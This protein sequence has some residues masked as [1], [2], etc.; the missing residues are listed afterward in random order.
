[1]ERARSRKSGRTEKNEWVVVATLGEI[2]KNKTDTL[3]ITRVKFA[4][5]ELINLQVWRTNPD[6]NKTFPLK[7]QKLSVNLDLRDKLTEAIA[8]AE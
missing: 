8:K 4:G 6:T 7:D 2:K 1:M 5:K 3:K